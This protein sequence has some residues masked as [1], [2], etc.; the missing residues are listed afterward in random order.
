MKSL[1]R[2]FIKEGD[3]DWDM[4]VPYVLFAYREVP[5]TTTGFSP[6]EILYRRKVRG[7][8]DILKE[9][10]EASGKSITGV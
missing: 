7:P 3:Q 8:L 10:W 6:F 1:L 9:E 5:Q 2:K 4:L